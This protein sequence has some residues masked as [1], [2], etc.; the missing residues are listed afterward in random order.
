MVFSASFCRQGQE[1]LGV[2]DEIAS[3]LRFQI[4]RVEFS[5]KQV[6]SITVLIIDYQSNAVVH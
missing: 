3:E 5:V 1:L 6:G 2:S 4:E